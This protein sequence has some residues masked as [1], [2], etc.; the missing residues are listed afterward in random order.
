MNVR[1]Y[2]SSYAN[3]DR[4]KIASIEKFK[5]CYFEDLPPLERD[6]SFNSIYSK[7]GLNLYHK[8]QKKIYH[9]YIGINFVYIFQNNPKNS[10]CFCS[11]FMNHMKFNWEELNENGIKMNC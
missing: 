9:P 4:N 6:V 3:R 10:Y 8:I 2:L 5:N 11:Y 1:S 7:D